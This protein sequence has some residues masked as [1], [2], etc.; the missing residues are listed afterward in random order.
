MKNPGGTYRA[1]GRGTGMGKIGEGRGSTSTVS[2]TADEVEG[3]ERNR[4][5]YVSLSVFLHVIGPTNDIP[6]QQFEKFL[7]SFKP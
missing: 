2:G 4:N 3:Q 6:G 7:E 1:R 5:F